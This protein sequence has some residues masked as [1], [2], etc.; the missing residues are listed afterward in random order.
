MK[1]FCHGYQSWSES[2]WRTVGVDPD[3]SSVPNVA[4]LVR[5]MHHPETALVPGELL[6]ELVTMFDD[7]PT[8]H[9]G[10]SLLRMSGTELQGATETFPSL[11]AWAEAQPGRVSAPFQVGWCSWYQYFDRVT[12]ADV[13]AN[14]AL[15]DAWPF[16]VFQIDDGFQ[17]SIGD[18]LRT[19]DKFPSSLE[20]LATDIARA[21]RRPGLWIAPFVA[22]PDSHVAREHPDWFAVHP[23]GNRLVGMV[24]DHWGGA[25]H[26][27]DTT[28]PEVIAHLEGLA[29][30]LVAAGFTYL[31]LD[32]TYAPS[33]GGQYA[34]PSVSA[35]ERVRAGFAAMRRGAGDNTFIL[36]CG[37]PIG[38]CIGLVDGM[39]IGPDVAPYW[40]PKARFGTYDATQ[41]S[42]AN[43]L[44]ATEA[45]QFMHR[46]LW[47]NDPDCV[48][49]RTADTE[50]TPE[51]VRRWAEAVGNSGGM[52]LVSDDLSLLGAD[53]H[54]LLDDVIARGR[55]VDAQTIGSTSA[56][57][58]VR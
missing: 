3:P 32:F 30:D 51:Q 27:L 20:T 29:R 42:T 5:S 9:A 17:S 50:L 28:K 14:L 18:W 21:G 58:N 34:D 35:R 56:R 49:L 55:E 31:K 25:V 41:P 53:A 57:T 22:S 46:R 4:S 44:A 33:I 13:R 52:V 37:A 10:D 54:T 38:P 12:E 45:R 6:S 39:R 1:M 26:V 19:N 48:M 8:V 47:L 36:G 40:N 16:D 43:A 15:A 11:E 7:D 24:N 23:N 2:A